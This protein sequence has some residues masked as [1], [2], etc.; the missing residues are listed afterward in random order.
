MKDR[1]RHIIGG[2]LITI[3]MLA[4]FGAVGTMDYNVENHIIQSETNLLVQGGIGVVVTIV[5]LLFCK[6][7]EFTLNEDDE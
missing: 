2:I 4:I 3:G 7:M 5:G 1:I 6:D